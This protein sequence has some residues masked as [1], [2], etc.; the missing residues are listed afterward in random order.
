MAQLSKTTVEQTLSPVPRCH[1]VRGPSLT[2]RTTFA[3]NRDSA[4]RG[5]DDLQHSEPQPRKIHVSI[6]RHYY[7]I[8]EQD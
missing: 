5:F 2:R 1:P 8:D 3:L 4:P 7:S 6:I